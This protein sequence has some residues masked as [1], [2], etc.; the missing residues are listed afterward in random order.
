MPLN[1][2]EPPK[3]RRLTHE[4][5]AMKAAELA[6]AFVAAQRTGRG[7][8]YDIGAATPSRTDT[9]RDGKVARRWVVRIQWTHGDATVDGPSLVNVN[10][11]TGEAT[12]AE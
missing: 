9:D 11:E 3:V 10:I 5:A 2:Y 1:P 6:R 7:W 8:Q 12:W 4:Q